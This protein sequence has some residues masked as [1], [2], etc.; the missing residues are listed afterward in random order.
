MLDALTLDQIRVFVAV[1]EEGSFRQAARRLSRVQSAVSHAIAN[2]EAELGVALFDRSGHKPV[3][4][5][6]GTALLEDACG[7]LLKADSLRARARGLGEGVELSLSLCIDVLYPLTAISDALYQM[8][9]IYPS[10]AIRLETAALGGPLTSLLD[11]RSQMAI[12]AGEDFRDPHITLDALGPVT[13]VAVAAPD[14]PLAKRGHGTPLGTADLV[15]HLQIVQA[16]PTAWS[17]GRDI[18]VLSPGTWRVGG[19]DSKHA[20]IRSGLGWGRLPLWAAK[21]DLAAGRLVRLNAVAL[22]RDGASVMGCYLA[23][24]NDAPLGPAARTLRRILLQRNSE[25]G[26][27]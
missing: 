18:G 5:R 12:T 15:E 10:V 22:G 21:E 11:G 25:E 2:L 1:A 4:T 9:E 13:F 3:L 20:L 7:I 19:Q 14:H 8:R 27:V 24:R 26:G 23:H 6:A 16:D 17:K